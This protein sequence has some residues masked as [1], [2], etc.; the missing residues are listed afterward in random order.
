MGPGSYYRTIQKHQIKSLCPML[1]PWGFSFPLFSHSFFSFY[2]L[3][4]LPSPSLFHLMLYPFKLF[5]FILLSPLCPYFLS[6]FLPFF[7]FS[8]S[9][10][11]FLLFFH[12][13]L[14][15][16]TFPTTNPTIATRSSGHIVSS[17][18]PTRFF[19]FSFKVLFQ[20][21]TPP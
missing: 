11:L 7:L 13:P 21:Q 5:P 20:P 17:R 6:P 16:S 19:P 1:T 18:C 3:T 14:L 9:L 10:L 8:S 2:F 12:H 4:I 15:Q